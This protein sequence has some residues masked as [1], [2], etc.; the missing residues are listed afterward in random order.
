LKGLEKKTEVMVLITLSVMIDLSKLNEKALIKDVDILHFHIRDSEMSS[1][2][3]CIL[4]NKPSMW[5]PLFLDR[6]N[7]I[8]TWYEI[9]DK[10]IML[11]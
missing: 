11:K 3:H 7:G 10:K 8:P 6:E 4:L 1:V 2:R 9:S 5:K